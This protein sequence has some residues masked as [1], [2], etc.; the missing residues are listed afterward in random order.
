MKFFWPNRANAKGFLIENLSSKDHERA[1]KS[2]SKEIQN[3][4]TVGSSSRSKKK[5]INHMESYVRPRKKVH[6]ANRDFS[7]YDD[8]T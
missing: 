8:V 7:E 6:W 4:C 2:S 5:I 3:Q 1:A